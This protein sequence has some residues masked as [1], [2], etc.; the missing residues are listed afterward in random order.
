MIVFQ[1]VKYAG[2]QAVES[3]DVLSEGQRIFNY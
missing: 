2:D 3:L 1:P